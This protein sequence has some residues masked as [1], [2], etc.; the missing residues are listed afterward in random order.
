M[1]LITK[2]NLYMNHSQHF[3]NSKKFKEYPHVK[4]MCQ[5]HVYSS[6]AICIT[7][8]ISKVILIVDI[9][10]FCIIT[11]LQTWSFC[12]QSTLI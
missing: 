8:K 12:I 10:T 5:M 9:N 3:N 11:V 2:S 1:Y 7:K 6:F 4:H